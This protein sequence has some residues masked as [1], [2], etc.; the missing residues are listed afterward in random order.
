[1]ADSSHEKDFLDFLR[2]PPSTTV[3]I[4]LP[5]WE[6]DEIL[7]L[8]QVLYPDMSVEQVCDQHLLHMVLTVAFATT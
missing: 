2:H 5:V 7:D 4:I 3:P 6:R 1:M 8:R